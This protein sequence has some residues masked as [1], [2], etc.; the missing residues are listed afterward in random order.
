MSGDIEIGDSE[1]ITVCNYE[2]LHC[3]EFEMGKS[4]RKVIL[5]NN[6]IKL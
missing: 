6:L 2:L 3:T 5:C 4:L 1:W